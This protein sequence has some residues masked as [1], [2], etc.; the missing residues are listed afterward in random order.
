[1]VK[2]IAGCVIA[3]WLSATDAFA[4][5]ALAELQRRFPLFEYQ[6]ISG[7]GYLC[8]KEQVVGFR[9]F[10]QRNLLLC[11]YSCPGRNNYS[12][13]FE[14]RA[15]QRGLRV[16]EGTPINASLSEH[17][18]EMDWV[19]AGSPLATTLAEVDGLHLTRGLAAGQAVLLADV[20]DTK[21]IISGQGVVVRVS[22]G[23][24]RLEVEGLLLYDARPGSDAVVNV[25]GKVLHG[26]INHEQIVE[27]Y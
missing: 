14:L 27:L 11:E 3:L 7:D 13:W 12:A 9:L 19:K 15:W 17:N 16:T 4:V 25:G 20:A 10:E 5:C 21:T 6:R 1:M 18:T 26:R 8:A 22:I 23:T 2:R 24:A